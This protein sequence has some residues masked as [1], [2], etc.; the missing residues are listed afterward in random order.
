MVLR[1]FFCLILASFLFAASHPGCIVKEG[2]AL[3]GYGALVPVFYA[4]RFLRAKTAFLWGFF[5]GALSYSLLCYWLFFYSPVA[6]CAVLVCY[7]LILALVVEL[8]VLLRR[9]FCNTFFYIIALLWCVYEFLKTR[10]FLGFSY[11]IMGYSQ[12]K[13]ILGLQSAS[14]G[15]VWLLSALCVF[16]S[17]I[18]ADFLYRLGHVS[19]GKSTMQKIRSSLC[20]IFLPG[21]CWLCAFSS[22]FVYGFFETHKKESGTV[23]TVSVL[24]V[25]NNTDSN[26]YG[27]DVYKRDVARLVSLTKTG[28]TEHPATDFVLWPETAVVPPIV[29]N[30]ET[31]RDAERL[32]LVHQLLSFMQEAGACFV[33]GNQM[34]VENESPYTDDYN[35]TLVFDAEV[36]NIIPPRPA[37]YAKIHL[38]PLSEYF[39]YQSIAPHLYKLLLGGET[40][41]WTPGT[42]KT[43]FSFRGIPFCTPICFEDSFG[44]LCRDFVQKG[45]RCFF[46]VSNDSWSQTESCQVQHLAMAVFRCAENR[47][48]A[49]RSTASG[50]TC[51]I[52]KHGRVLSPLPMFTEA[53]AWGSVEISEGTEKS[54][55]TIAGDWLPLV[56]LFIFVL[57]IAYKLVLRV[58]TRF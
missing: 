38:V 16:C 50:V 13:W 15:G 14:L 20:S 34:S 19:A 30:Y 3:A 54:A 11:G 4:S 40:H 46:M 24:C 48:P 31:Q 57:C 5:Y 58:K 7:G 21:L 51:F 28:L 26:K 53:T 22:I 56:E 35:A 32:T 1:A 9:I 18:L 23:K 44:A 2:C 45:A 37:T 55:Y 29:W 39:P 10:G 47:I 43:V 52:D 6:L 33:L 8:C 41:L 36:G 49:A 17:A 25:Q 27:L 12:W 42:E